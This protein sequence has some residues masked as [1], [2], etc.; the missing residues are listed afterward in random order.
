[1]QNSKKAISFLLMI[2]LCVCLT[3]CG[4][5]PT[6]DTTSTHTSTTASVQTGFTTTTT[7]DT[8]TA[9]HGSTTTET[10]KVTTTTSVDVTTTTQTTDSKTTVTVVP[11]TTAVP[12]VTTVML[13]T[14][15]VAPTT[16]T[17]VSTTTVD[18]TVKYQDRAP[19]E[20]NSA[21]VYG[22]LNGPFDARADAMRKSILNLPDTLKNQSG[23]KYYVSQQNGDDAN[24]GTAPDKAWKTLS[25]VSG[26]VFSAGDIVLFERGGVYRGQLKVRSNVS[27]GAYGNGPKPA[28]YRS[29]KNYATVDWERDSRKNVYYYQSGLTNV[30]VAVFNHGAIKSVRQ[31]SIGALASRSA[32]DGWY[33]VSG[34]R[35]YIYSENGSPSESF[36]SIEIGEDGAAIDAANCNNV[37]IENLSLRYGG[38]HGI[39]GAGSTSNITV[40]GCEI[41][42]FG[43]A[44]QGG[45]GTVLYG[46]GIEWWGKSQNNLVENC[47]IYQCYDAG[48]T[49]QDS[50]GG[51]AKQ[52]T[53]RNN[54]VE[55]CWYSTEMWVGS[56]ENN[57]VIEDI[58]LTGNHMRFAAYGWGADY[59]PDKVNGSHMF[60]NSSME[61]AKNF[62]VADNIFEGAG[63]ALFGHTSTMQM[64]GN[65][66][67]Q[68][69]DGLFSGSYRFDDTAAKTAED[70]FG[71]RNA[72]IQ[73]GNWK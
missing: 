49:F 24:D 70:V 54:L 26:A 64:N 21:Q 36:V 40:R 37:T 44:I 63:M 53:F 67:V 18:S 33:A 35:V 12:T 28:I 25:R 61:L 58:T 73:Y 42:W 57:T 38:G 19:S 27:Y 68:L 32:Q 47:W 30:G 39:G 72:T 2:C 71:D 13:T 51:P 45:S 11:S 16:T 23:K 43:G 14:T 22:G 10:E 6:A 31:K 41:G 17:V 62:T 52:H 65:T 15:T 7:V 55:Y 20:L 29:E 8:T 66:Y 5:T 56:R 69:S 50:S 4:S 3:A 34:N 9:T 46:N 48:W 1:M 60:V 59:R